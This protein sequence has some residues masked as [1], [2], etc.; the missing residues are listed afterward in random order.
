M[1]CDATTRKLQGL[2]SGS[3]A[4]TN[5]VVVVDWVD[6]TTT[7]TTGGCTTSSLNGTTA[8]DIMPAPAA[9]TQRKVNAVTLFNSDTASVTV[10]I[11][12]NDNATLYTLVRITLLTGETLCYSDTAGWFT[13]DT[14]GNFKGT[15]AIAVHATS[16]KHGG[17]DEVATAT[18]AANAIPKA[19]GGGKLDAWVSS[20]AS[21]TKGLIELDTDLGNTASAP[22]VVGLKGLALPTDVAD[23]FLKMNAANSAREQV[24]Y[25][26]AAN[27]VAQGNDIRFPSVHR[28]LRMLR[29]DWMRFDSSSLYMNPT[30]NTAYFTYL[31]YV[32]VAT[33]FAFVRFVLETNASGTVAVEVGLF[34]TPSAPNR[35]NQTVTKL[36]AD[37]TLGDLTTGGGGGSPMRSNTTTLA[38]TVAAGTHLWA[39]IRTAF[40][41]TQP[42]IRSLKYDNLQGTC[43]TTAS[44]G[45]LTGAGPWTGVVL[46]GF[47]SHCPD[48]QVTMD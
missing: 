26:I 1:I 31:G 44:A 46:S 28:S 21:G 34:S 43:L 7:T 4:T 15:A 23:G 3:A 47:T 10:T 13:L 39:G 16:H 33:T 20:A 41:V 8:V 32:A 25:G 45:V 17:T 30:P 29:N 42:G 12:Y 38:Y 24:A 22:N 48:L 18:P 9:S 11:R 6:L 2:L 40:S 35:A 5:P 37:A 19:D 14:S 27:T 36:V